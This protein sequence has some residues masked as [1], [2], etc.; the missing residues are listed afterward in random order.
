ML[1]SVVMS[2]STKR[3]GSIS[4]RVILAR[5]GQASHNPRAEAAKA[6]GCSHQKFM[7]LMKDDD[8]YDAALTELG[9]LQ[10]KEGREKYKK[11]LEKVDIVVSSPLSRAI[12]TADLIIKSHHNKV[13][14][15]NFREI[16]G[17]LLNAKRRPRD[18][19]QGLYPSWDF[20]EVSPLDKSWVPDELERQEDCAERGYQGLLWAACRSET[21]VLIVSH[22]GLLRFCME[23]HPLV[24][25]HD[26]RD[27][28]SRRFGNCEIREY[29]MTLEF[30]DISEN[31]EVGDINSISLRRP[32]VTL[33]E[34]DRKSVV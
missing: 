23:L 3:N 16:T 20:S 32:I 4:K 18:E 13:V 25:I 5:H 7:D 24:K 29:D 19:L 26:Q 11:I 34:S 2:M 1:L 14:V 21:N 27:S 33:T 15:D 31:D 30:K 17:L 9:R 22:G 12:D 8:E 6:R 28:T 10:A